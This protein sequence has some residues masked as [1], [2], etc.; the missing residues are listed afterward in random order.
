MTFNQKMAESA[1]RYLRD[2]L[3]RADGNVSE[4][5]R[6]SGR[7]RSNFYRLC[8]RYQ[9][10]PKPKRPYAVTSFAGWPHNP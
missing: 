8:E 10:I 7:C 5:A 4:A 3:V 2:C 9:V 1:Q 6:L